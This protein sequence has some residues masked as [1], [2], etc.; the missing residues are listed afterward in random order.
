MDV[1]VSIER[2]VKASPVRWYGPFLRREEGNILKEALHFEVT[3]R[4][5][6]ERPKATWKNRFKV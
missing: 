1:A 4:R 6:K 5:K 2:M 3:G